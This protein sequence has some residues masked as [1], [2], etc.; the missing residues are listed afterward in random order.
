MR[1]PKEKRGAA[2]SEW[3]G[4]AS[5]VC[6]PLQR[7]EHKPIQY[8]SHLVGLIEGTH[9]HTYNARLNA[10]SRAALP[11]YASKRHPFYFGLYTG[12]FKDFERAFAARIYGSIRA[13]LCNHFITN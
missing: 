5:C 4:C 3:R 10:L 8:I 13:V 11:K 7:G 6:A 1:V 12:H 2:H 9:T